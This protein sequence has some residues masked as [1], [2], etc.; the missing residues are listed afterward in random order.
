[1]ITGIRIIKTI[2]YDV[3]VGETMTIGKQKV[4]V[5]GFSDDLKHIN[6]TPIYDDRTLLNPDI[7]RLKPGAQYT[8]DVHT[9][10]PEKDVV[11]LDET[12][13]PIGDIAHGDKL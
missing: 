9:L 3:R 5:S 7:R 4:S 10:K 1:M 12:R 6:L 2:A 13:L 11:T 8:L